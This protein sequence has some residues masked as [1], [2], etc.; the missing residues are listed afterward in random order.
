MD[1]CSKRDETRL[2]SSACRCD[3]LRPKCRNLRA[4]PAIFVSKGGEKSIEQRKGRDMKSW[5]PSRVGGG[6]SLKAEDHGKGGREEEK[7]N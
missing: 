3:D 4:P 2:R 6:W 5:S 7:S 1:S